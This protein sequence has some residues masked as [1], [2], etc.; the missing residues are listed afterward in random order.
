MVKH[1]LSRCTDR[2]NRSKWSQ[3]S[4][5]DDGGVWKSTSEVVVQFVVID[6][7]VADWAVDADAVAAAVTHVVDPQVLNDDVGCVVNGDADAVELYKTRERSTHSAWKYANVISANGWLLH[8]SLGDCSTCFLQNLPL[9][10][11]STCFLQNL[12]L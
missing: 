2:C 7:D 8:L 9:G 1:L 5:R 10:D 12:S 11:C 3:H 4:I 6:P